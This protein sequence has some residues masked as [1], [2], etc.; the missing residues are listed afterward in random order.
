MYGKEYAL[1]N[2]I[3]FKLDFLRRRLCLDEKY[4]VISLDYDLGGG[5]LTYGNKNAKTTMYI[6]LDFKLDIEKYTKSLII[7]QERILEFKQCM[8]DLPSYIFV[9]M[10]E[11]GHYITMNKNDY[12]LYETY[13]KEANI[14][15]D[16]AN[17]FAIE[18]I[19]VN[20]SAIK[21]I[22]D[23]DWLTIGMYDHNKLFKKVNDKSIKDL[24]LDNALRKV[25]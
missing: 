6:N 25:V 14:Y 17:H 9:F 15:E 16:I 19:I 2:T 23:N 8:K 18:S 11:L 1:K 3:K 20:S 24:Y 5:A 22:L 21:F 12:K 7:N 4:P 10:H 13:D